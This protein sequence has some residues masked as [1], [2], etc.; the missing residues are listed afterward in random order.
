[1]PAEVLAD[2]WNTC[3]KTLVE[4]LPLEQFLVAVRVPLMYELLYRY[5]CFIVYYIT[6]SSSTKLTKLSETGDCPPCSV[7]ACFCCTV[8]TAWS[9]ACCPASLALTCCHRGTRGFD[10]SFSGA[11]VG[12]FHRP[13]YTE[14]CA[15]ERSFPLL[16]P[17]SFHGIFPSTHSAETSFRDMYFTH[18]CLILDSKR[19]LASKSLCVTVYTHRH[20]D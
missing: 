2:V 17:V 3:G 19:A 18:C 6:L 4:Q 8:G 15:S 20:S 13:T 9:A 14:R 7:K 10:S 11:S 5:P 16:V 12:S 1:M